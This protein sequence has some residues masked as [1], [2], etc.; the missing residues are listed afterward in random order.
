[1]PDTRTVLISLNTLSHPGPPLVE[2]GSLPR[3]Y[4]SAVDIADTVQTIE[5]CDNRIDGSECKRRWTRGICSTKGESSTLR[6]WGYS[7][8]LRRPDRSDGRERSPHGT[9]SL[10]RR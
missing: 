8:W 3:F 6:P 2:N 10:D 1:M 9:G 4:A 5:S 7:R